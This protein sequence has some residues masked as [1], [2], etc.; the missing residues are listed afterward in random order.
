MTRAM[1]PSRSVR[2]RIRS[3]G[4]IQDNIHRM[5][6][7]RDCNTCGNGRYRSTA[8]CRGCGGRG[9]VAR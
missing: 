1:K 9:R 4:R 3:E 6:A 2:N 5:R 8:G 7:E